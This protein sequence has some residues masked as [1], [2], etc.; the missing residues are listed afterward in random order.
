M[1]L[2]RNIEKIEMAF[3]G[4]N[5]ECG[6]FLEIPG[7]S[8]KSIKN[9]KSQL[10]KIYIYI[11]E[12]CLVMCTG[13]INSISLDNSFSLFFSYDFTDGYVNPKFVWSWSI[14]SIIKNKN[15]KK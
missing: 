14:Q 1:K 9:Q 8:C 7:T 11:G 4:A 3:Q 13:N 10:E 6:K 12:L 2:K 5:I 15:T